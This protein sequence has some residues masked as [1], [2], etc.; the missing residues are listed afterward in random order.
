[1]AKTIHGLAGSAVNFERAGL[2]INRVRNIEELDG[3]SLPDSIEF[4]GYIPEDDIIRRADIDEMN[5][6]QN[7]RRRRP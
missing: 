7:C 3:V 5:I 1:M 2:I 6:L 4:L